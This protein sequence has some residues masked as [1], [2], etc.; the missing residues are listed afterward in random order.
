MISVDQAKRYCCEDI[1][2]IEN[3]AEAVVSLEQWV[4]HHRLGITPD[5]KTLTHEELDA[6]GLYKKRPASELIFMKRRD[7]GRLHRLGRK[8]SDETRKKQ[9]LART[10]EKNPFY[11]KRHNE[12]TKDL[13]RQKMQGENHP[14]YGKRWFNNGEKNILSK[15]CP[16]GFRPGRIRAIIKN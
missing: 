4:C 3:Y 14:C 2:L 7:H 5:G 13:M 1:S 9:S 15:E 6:M 11:G 8:A 12:S 16:P 10:G